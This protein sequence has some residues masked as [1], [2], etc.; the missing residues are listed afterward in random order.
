MPRHEHGRPS[1]VFCVTYSHVCAKFLKKVKLVKF[2]LM[3]FL[4]KDL[5]VRIV[6]LMI[7]KTL[8]FIRMFYLVSTSLRR[9]CQN[10][11]YYNSGYLSQ[12]GL[13]RH[14]RL[15]CYNFWIFVQFNDIDNACCRKN[16]KCM[17][18]YSEDFDPYHRNQFF[19]FV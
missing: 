10:H 15:W 19:M 9:Q 1:N 6:L 7:W 16:I 18:K 5:N 17:I 13:M 8:Q 12:I 2:Y 4:Y 11:K 14:W 3:M